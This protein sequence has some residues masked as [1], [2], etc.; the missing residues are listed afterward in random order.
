MKSVKKYAVFAVAL[1]CL[2][3]AA[4][5]RRSEVRHDDVFVP[6]GQTTRGD[7]VTD[8]SITVDGILGGDAI[9]V[10]GGS[11]TVNGEVTGDLVAVGGAISVAGLV[12][13]DLASI[14]GPVKITGKVARDVT[15]VGGVVDLSGAGEIGGGVSVLG[16]SFLKSEKAVHKGE[17]NNFDLR[18]VRTVMPR[19]LRAVRFAGDHDNASPWLIG[20]LIGIGLLFLLSVLATG[21]ILLLLPAVF[22]PRNVENA[23]TAISRD[24]WR[25]CG[26]GAL[27]VVGF[28]PGLLMMIVSILGIPLVPFALMVYAAAGIVGLS[29]FSVVLQNRFFEGIKKA[30]PASLPGKVTAGYALMAGLLLFGKMIPLVGGVLSLIGFMLLSFGAVLGL[31]AAVMTRLGNRPYEP[32]VLLVPQ[33][34]AAS[35]VPP[36]TPAQ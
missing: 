24:M 23:A 36:V 34:P 11:V 35:P 22:F 8:K 14:G 27:L 6:K 5:A 25:A 31:G 29:G 13:G 30:G 19:V 33:P 32:G 12:K 20:G 9:A 15:S 16:G 3:Q 2:G 7:I 1:L 28:F 10:G 21:A 26:I 18:A 4:Q 17:V